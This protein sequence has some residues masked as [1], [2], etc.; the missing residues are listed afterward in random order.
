[1]MIVAFSEK[2]DAPNGL[3]T[4]KETSIIRQMWLD[5]FR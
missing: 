3:T 2:L 4:L 1:M 5:R